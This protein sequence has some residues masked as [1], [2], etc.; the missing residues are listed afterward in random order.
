MQVIST[1]HLWHSCNLS[2]VV[3]LL[4]MSATRS[5]LLLVAFQFSYSCC[6]HNNVKFRSALQQHCGA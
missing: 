2:L 4:L 6:L 1:Q 3:H 5:S